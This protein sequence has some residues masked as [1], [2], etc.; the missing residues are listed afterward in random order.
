MFLNF[1]DSF[2]LVGSL[3]NNLVGI[4]TKKRNTINI[5]HCS[6]CS[7]NFHII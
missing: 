5:V 1:L 6:K 7:D 4:N 3:D 2:N